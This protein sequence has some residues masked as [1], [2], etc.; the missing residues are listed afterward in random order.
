MATPRTNQAM[1]MSRRSSSVRRHRPA[2]VPDQ[3]GGG[4]GDLIIDVADVS[5]FATADRLASRNGTA[6]IEIPSGKPQEG[7]P[8]VH[9][10]QPPPTPSTWPQSPRSPASTAT[11][12]YHQR[13]LAEGKTPSEA[14]RAAAAAR[15]RTREPH[16]IQRGRL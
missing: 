10:R 15:E 16:C 8:A 11:A 4:I 13:K 7:Q 14:R 9:A 3:L 5:R 1:R 6:P 2:A 12:T